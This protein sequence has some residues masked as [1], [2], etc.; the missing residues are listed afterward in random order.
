[1]SNYET[2]QFIMYIQMQLVYSI[3]LQ[4]KGKLKYT[5]IPQTNL[6]KILETHLYFACITH[7]L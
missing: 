7:L 1:M 5:I 6:I 4:L 2:L 3:W